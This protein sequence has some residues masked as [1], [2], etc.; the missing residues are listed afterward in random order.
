[1]LA[2]RGEV[3]ATVSGEMTPDA[4]SRVARFLVEIEI[5]GEIDADT[6]RRRAHEAETEICTASNTLRGD[7]VIEGRYLDTQSG[8]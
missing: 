4:P 2:L 5:E 8:G 1:V 3:R 7:P 6:K